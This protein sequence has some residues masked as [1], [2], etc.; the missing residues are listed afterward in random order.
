M[1]H[2]Q[3]WVTTHM[4]SHSAIWLVRY[5]STTSEGPFRLCDSTWPMS[6]MTIVAL[7]TWF[8]RVVKTGP[9]AA[10]YDSFCIDISP[11]YNALIIYSDIFLKSNLH[12]TTLRAELNMASIFVPCMRDTIKPIFRRK[13]AKNARFPLFKKKEKRSYMSLRPKRVFFL[14]PSPPYADK[15]FL[16]F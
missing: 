8:H 7:T 1:F 13:M 5:A 11:P 15:M 14:Y 4:W 10:S 9:Q 3:I 16:P 2:A 6:H 12:I